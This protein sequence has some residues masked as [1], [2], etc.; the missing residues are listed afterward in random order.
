MKMFVTR[1]ELVSAT[2]EDYEVLHAEMQKELFTRSIVSNAG[3][4]FNLPPAEYY[5]EGNYTVHDVIEAAKRAASLAHEKFRVLTVEANAIT[6]YNLEFKQ[7][8]K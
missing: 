3:V 8:R 1:V 6:S 2:S 4:E 5:R 7:F